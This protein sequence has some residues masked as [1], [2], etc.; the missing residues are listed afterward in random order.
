[1]IL[2]AP[3]TSPRNTG[4]EGEDNDWDFGT[5]ASFTWMPLLSLGDRTTMYS[6]VVRELPALIAEHF[7]NQSDRASLVI[8]WAVTGH[9]FVRET[10]IATSQFQLLHHRGTDALPVGQKA[11]THYLGSDKENWRAYDASVLIRSA[12]TEP[13]LIDQGT[14]DPFLASSCFLMC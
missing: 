3:D 7:C 8:L 9:L 2:V 11:F 1:M 10:L 14:A 4:I 6:Y 12:I 5:G 13:I